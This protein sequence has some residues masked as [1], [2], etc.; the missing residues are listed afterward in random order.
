MSI[1][2]DLPTNKVLKQP[3]RQTTLGFDFKVPK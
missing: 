3:N 1:P 2:G